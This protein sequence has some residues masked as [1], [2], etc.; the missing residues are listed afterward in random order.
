MKWS[1]CRPL[2]F[3]QAHQWKI[4]SPQR[5][6]GNDVAVFV[7]GYGAAHSLLQWVLAQDASSNTSTSNS[8]E[9]YSVPK[10]GEFLS[11]V[12]FDVWLCDSL[13]HLPDSKS[14]HWQNQRCHQ[15]AQCEV[16]RFLNA[17]RYCQCFSMFNKLFRPETVK[18]LL[19][20]FLSL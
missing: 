13:V 17:F 18:P 6:L 8:D 15:C 4:W 12:K 1:K 14:I 10:S 7:R 16:V 11:L 3:T 5:I 20:N 2:A 19:R 9:W